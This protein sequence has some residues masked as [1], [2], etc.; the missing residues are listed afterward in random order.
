M[1]SSNANVVEDLE[2]RIQKAEELAKKW[3][4]IADDL[5]EYFYLGQGT[6][7]CVKKYMDA[8]ND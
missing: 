3:K 1:T 5:Y 4:A 7:T 2:T 6:S 8:V